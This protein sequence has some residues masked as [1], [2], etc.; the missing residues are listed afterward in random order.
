KTSDDVFDL[1]N[2]DEFHFNTLWF[3][4]EILTHEP[5]NPNAASSISTIQVWLS[6]RQFLL[7]GG[8]LGEEPQEVSIG[9]RGRL[10]VARPGS[11]QPW[12]QRVHS[13]FADPF[14]DP[15]LLSGLYMLFGEIDELT[16]SEFVA[17]GDSL[18]AGRD[19]WVVSQLDSGG[20][21]IGLLYLDQ[22]TGFILRYRKLADPEISQESGDVLP[23]EVIVKSISYAVDF[24]Q[25]LFDL[26]LPWRGG[27]AADHTGRPGSAYPPESE[28]STLSYN[29]QDRQTDLPEGLD[30][31][32]ARLSFRF[33]IG[34][35]KYISMAGTEIYVDDYYLGRVDMGIPW[36]STCQRSPD[37]KV[38][39]YRTMSSD[40]DDLT[41]L[42]YGPYY[43]ALSRPLEIRRI[44]PGARR[45]ASD[46]AIS[47]DSRYVAIWACERNGEPCGVYLHD[48]HNHRWQRL[49]DIQ[50]GAS[51]FLWSPEGDQLALRTAEDV[52]WVVSAEDGE[53][54]YTSQNDVSD[55]SPPPGNPI[56][57]WG[58]RFPP[59]ASG[60][61]ACINPPGDW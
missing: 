39:V 29:T 28:P 30:L 19:S 58:F 47:P 46:F 14:I 2:P 48:I 37:G 12:F 35:Y 51:D 49:I 6:P 5:Q 60:L 41:S 18:S 52:V 44:L 23:D 15:S 45:V 16:R 24:P 34:L 26:S 22:E 20:D 8:R 17:M 4:A 38:L 3:S 9:M 13:R 57:E 1:L 40:K 21:R 31:S 11:D 10:Y 42:S 55:Q 53:L 43:L 50:D 33:P 61:E 36:S 25:E 56:D 32:S 59:R 7:I 54:L 27:Y